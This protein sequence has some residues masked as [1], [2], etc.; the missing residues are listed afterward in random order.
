VSHRA[1]HPPSIS[2]RSSPTLI[3]YRAAAAAEAGDARARAGWSFSAR[4]ARASGVNWLFA[5]NSCYASAGSAPRPCYACCAT[6]CTGVTT[7]SAPTRAVHAAACPGAS[8]PRHAPSHPAARPRSSPATLRRRSCKSGPHQSWVA[9]CSARMQ[10]AWH[11][12]TGAGIAGCCMGR[13]TPGRSSRTTVPLGTRGFEAHAQDRLGSSRQ[14]GYHW[15]GAGGRGQRCTVSCAGEERAPPPTDLG[16][17][18]ARRRASK[19]RSGHRMRVRVRAA[20]DNLAGW[21]YVIMCGG[22]TVAIRWG[23]ESHRGQARWGHSRPGGPAA[24]G[25]R[26]A[27]ARPPAGLS[28]C[29]VLSAACRNP[30]R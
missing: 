24:R 18:A 7:T 12:A 20:S 17:A 26:R 1:R 25:Q 6:L 13:G 2:H 4:R 3:A 21:I 23:A 22:G 16:A 28:V 8:P 15:Q 19:G 11:A 9:V 10:Q 5:I 27:R 29:S 30:A 14:S